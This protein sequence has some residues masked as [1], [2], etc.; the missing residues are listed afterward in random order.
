VKRS[1]DC[2][3][4]REQH[5]FTA[6]DHYGVHARSDFIAEVFQQ[7]REW[8]RTGQDSG[9]NGPILLHA[10]NVQAIP[11]IG[12][13]AQSIKERMKAVISENGA[14]FLA[15]CRLCVSAVSDAVSRLR[16]QTVL[17]GANQAAFTCR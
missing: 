17:L 14:H 12:I 5:L 16:Q 2:H 15:V 9:F 4:A 11:R 8:D 3:Q 7:I 6:T 1:L 10:V 13:K